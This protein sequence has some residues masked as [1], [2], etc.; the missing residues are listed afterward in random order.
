MTTPPGYTALTTGLALLE[1]E[2]AL[3]HISGSRAERVVNGLV[4]NAIDGLRE[5]RGCY[6]FAL[7]AKGRPLTDMRI[8]P[9]PG[10]EESVA[11]EGVGEDIW[12]DVPAEGADAFR[13]LLTRSVP[14]IFAT[15]EELPVRRLS[16]TGPDADDAGDALRACEVV[17]V[18]GLPIPSSPLHVVTA[19][20][21]GREGRALL[22]RRE[23]IEGGGVDLYAPAAG[24]ESLKACLAEAVARMG[25]AV[26]TAAD[27]EVASVERGLPRYGA[28][29]TMDNLPQETG[30]TERSIS[31]S[32]GCYTG[33]EVVA[34]IHYRGH[35]NRLLRGVRMNP[36]LDAPPNGDGWSLEAGDAAYANGR[37]VGRV[38]TAVESPR[39][40]PIGLAYLRREIEPGTLVSRSGTA[41]P[42]LEVVELPFT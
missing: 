16:L 19:S 34:R 10:F 39:L 18:D 3:F 23:A 42:D 27:W 33:Q 6:A 7:T 40:G 5:G 2:R 32:K 31:F 17:P 24:A 20:V 30:Q 13:D 38:V 21:P 41:Q 28:E 29:I 35:V 14:P 26:A 15:V 11:D 4:T 9:A 22:V 25:G 12:I 36:S 1:T 8:L 37:E